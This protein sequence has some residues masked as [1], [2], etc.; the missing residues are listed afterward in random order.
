MRNANTRRAFTLV[1]LLVVIAIIGILVSLLMPAVQ[2]AREAA[3]RAQCVNNLKQMALA[4]HNHHDAKGRF[5]A[6]FEDWLPGGATATA[7]ENQNPDWCWAVRLMPYMEL[8]SVYESLMVD[9][10]K[11]EDIIHACAGLPGNAPITAY[12]PQYQE[13]V[14]VTSST[15][16]VFQCPSASNNILT[17]FHDPEI[18]RRDEGIGKSNYV[19]CTGVTTNGGALAG[20]PGGA[21]IYMK[22][23]RFRDFLDGTSNTML[24]GE[25]ALKDSTFDEATWLGTPKSLG[26]G[27][28]G[29][30]VV[31]TAQ[32]VLNPV[33]TDRVSAVFAFSSFHE[34]GANFAFTDGSVHFI[35]ETIEFKWHVS[36]KTVWGTYQK[37][38]HRAD[39]L[40]TGN[41]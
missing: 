23:M 12:P 2:A 9:K 39:G 8:N 7:R 33:P 18:Y 41:F 25:R 27:A 40:T 14:R 10:E 26:N 15:I 38:A 19:G 11:L 4:A 29:K 31:G 22:E 36:D 6:G 24:I 35:S 3:R 1:E 28:H 13:F 30:R 20:D 34:G 5:P 17:S 37:L 21:F 32:Y 16:P